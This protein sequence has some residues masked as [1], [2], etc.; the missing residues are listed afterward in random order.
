MGDFNVKVERED[1][2][3]QELVMTVYIKPVI[4]M[5]SE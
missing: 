4:I 3:N 2:L 5:G 1:F